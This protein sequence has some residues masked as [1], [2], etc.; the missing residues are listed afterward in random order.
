MNTIYK[1]VSTLTIGDWTRLFRQLE[2]AGA[3]DGSAAARLIGSMT[4]REYEKVM[5]LGE[6][7]LSRPVCAAID[8]NAFLDAYALWRKK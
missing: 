8:M 3:E 2:K 7:L 6:D 1:Q 4:D 5:S